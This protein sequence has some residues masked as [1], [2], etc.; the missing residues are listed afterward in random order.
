MILVG[1]VALFSQFCFEAT[2]R[3]IAITPFSS[4]ASSFH[5]P[6][7]LFI[8]RHSPLKI[9]YLARGF[10]FGIH[11]LVPLCYYRVR[12][13]SKTDRDPSSDPQPTLLSLMS[14][15]GLLYFLLSCFSLVLFPYSLFTGTPI[16]WQDFP[17]DNTTALVQPNH[18]AD[19]FDKPFL[20]FSFILIYGLSTSIPASHLHIQFLPVFHLNDLYLYF[21]PSQCLFF[22][23][24]L[25]YYPV[26]LS[27]F[28]TP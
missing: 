20:F 7:C 19:G 21:P 23:V 27:S 1:K 17:G 11:R 10:P 26:S 13:K 14:P 12:H 6:T 28:N 2:N 5:D 16:Q 22:M 4:P 15:L 18:Q 24:S 3:L 8:T 25:S 9:P